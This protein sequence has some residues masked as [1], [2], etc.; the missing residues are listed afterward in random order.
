MEHL[1]MR[2]PNPSRQYNPKQM[3]LESNILIDW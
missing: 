3:Q 2:E 1:Q